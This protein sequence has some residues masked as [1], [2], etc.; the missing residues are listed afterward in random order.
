MKVK[1]K[2]R[3]LGLTQDYMTKMLGNIGVPKSYGILE[4]EKMV[5][6]TNASS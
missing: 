4:N 2:K 1:E 3:F 6:Q 5:H